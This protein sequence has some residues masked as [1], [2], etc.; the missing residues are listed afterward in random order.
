MNHREKSFWHGF[1]LVIDGMIFRDSG[2]GD[3]S[4]VHAARCRFAGKRGG[5]EPD[6]GQADAA[7]VAVTCPRREDSSRILFIN[8]AGRPQDLPEHGEQHETGNRDHQA[9]QA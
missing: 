8:D 2:H 4:A 1:C 7:L 9:V 6:A 3:Q 5:A